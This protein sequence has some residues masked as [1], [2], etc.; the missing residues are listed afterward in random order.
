MQ[1]VECER[2]E[3]E[4]ICNKGPHSDKSLKFFAAA[5][6]PAEVSASSVETKE[7]TWKAILPTVA[8]I[9]QMCLV[10]VDFHHVLQTDPHVRSFISNIWP[11]MFWRLNTPP[12]YSILQTHT[13]SPEIFTR[14]DNGLPWKNSAPP[15]V[16]LN[17][18]LVNVYLL[19][20]CKMNS[21]KQLLS[22]AAGW[23]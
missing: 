21:G 9:F 20:S 6:L 2:K 13:V 18:V 7:T 22:V 3:K 10:R 23:V 15:G 4:G 16:R 14:Q 11:E 17:F 1:K 8:K 19:H 12:H 5:L